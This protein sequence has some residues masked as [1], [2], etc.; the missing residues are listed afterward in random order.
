MFPHD[1]ISRCSGDSPPMPVR[2]QGHDPCRGS[3]GHLGHNSS[4][5]RSLLASSVTRTISCPGDSYWMSAQSLDFGSHEAAERMNTWIVPQ[6]YMRDQVKSRG[7]FRSWRQDCFN[8]VL[9]ATED[10]RER[11]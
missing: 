3:L 10:D 1:V 7:E 2:L 11:R 9:R 5:R 4:E 6:I 8:A